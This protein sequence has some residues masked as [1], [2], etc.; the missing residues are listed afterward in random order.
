MTEQISIKSVEINN[1]VVPLDNITFCISVS[2]FD[3]ES[4]D[5]FYWINI[6]YRD[7]T[8]LSIGP[9]NTIAESKADIEKII[10][11]L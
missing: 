2:K 6:H 1:T 11:N 10:I 9:Y 8:I 3:K 5:R 4:G 7:K